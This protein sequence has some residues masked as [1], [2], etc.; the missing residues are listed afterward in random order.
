MIYNFK[1]E[2]IDCFGN[3]ITERVENPTTKVTTV[4]TVT[5][6]EKIARLLYNASRLSGQ[7]LNK[8]QKYEAYTLS[9]R[10][11]KSPEAVE[12]STEEAHF[13]KTLCLESLSAGA[14]GFIDDIFEQRNV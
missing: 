9:K 8:E 13:V 2:F 4:V 14:Y 7:P 11:A 3:P 12:L 6:W 5:V 10:I 1:K